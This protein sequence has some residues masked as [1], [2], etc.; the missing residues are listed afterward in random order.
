[1]G[2]DNGFWV[3]LTPDRSTKVK[4]DP[5]KETSAFDLNTRSDRFLFYYPVSV[6]TDYFHVTLSHEFFFSLCVL[7]LKN[8]G[9]TLQ[10]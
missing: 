2:V 9:D 3:S 5:R 7:R 6:V 4:R 1:M 8:W 10:S